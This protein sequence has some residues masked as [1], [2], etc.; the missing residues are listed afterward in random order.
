MKGTEGVSVQVS[1]YLRKINQTAECSA[2]WILEEILG[3]R[4][5]EKQL[6]W[7]LWERHAEGGRGGQDG[8][9]GQTRRRAYTLAYLLHSRLN[10]FPALSHQIVSNTLPLQP[11][12]QKP[13]NIGTPFLFKVEII[14]VKEE[15]SSSSG[16]PKRLMLS[17]KP[18]S[19]V[20]EL[21]LWSALPGNLGGRASHAQWQTGRGD[22]WRKRSQRWAPAL[23]GCEGGSSLGHRMQEEMSCRW[24]AERTRTVSTTSL[25]GLQDIKVDRQLEGWAHLEKRACTRCK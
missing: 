16:I 15:I 25:Q 24:K 5:L 2:D 22:Q 19:L 10:T 1:L 13:Y 21:C 23:S 20:P 12:T 18:R 7:P 17:L 3:R 4:S 9:W 14:K 11:H 6:K 8:G